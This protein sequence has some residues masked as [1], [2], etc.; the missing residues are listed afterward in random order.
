M[1]PNQKKSNLSRIEIKTVGTIRDSSNLV[2]QINQNFFKRFNKNMTISVCCG[3]VTGEKS[4]SFISIYHDDSK[5]QI[6]EVK[7][8]RAELDSI[9]NF[10]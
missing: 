7:W 1:K 10:Q 6:D 8:V 4:Y 2:A 5:G 3:I 9:Q